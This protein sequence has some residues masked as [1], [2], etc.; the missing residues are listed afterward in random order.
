MTPL[1]LSSRRRSAPTREEIER[2]WTDSL[3]GG[4]P[5]PVAERLL[6]EAW[7]TRIAA[8]EVFYS[9]RDGAMVGL[10]L[11]GLVRTFL[12]SPDGRQATVRYAGPAALVGAPAL[13]TD[14]PLAAVE[15]Q[16][17]YE[18]TMLRLPR[19]VFGALARSESALAFSIARFLA[20]HVGETQE[21]LA[22][23][24]FGD[25][26]SRVARHLLDLAVPT[27]RG[28][29]VAATHQDVADAIGSVREV[30]SRAIRRMQAE[31]LVERAGSSMVI[32]D[33]AR[34]QAVALS[35]AAAH[36]QQ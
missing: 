25:V 14:R 34:L 19:K 2:I 15:G 36:Q 23:N 29:V 18:T 8:G 17:V 31:G 24:M 26:R 33:P 32:V 27:D 30:V 12:R 10:V 20:E 13:L 5:Q 35:R 16:A 4:L 6:E 28:L 22:S 3:L 7:T 11:S 21:I 1:G 9:G